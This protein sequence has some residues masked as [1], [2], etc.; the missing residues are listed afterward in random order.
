MWRLVMDDQ[1]VRMEKPLGI[2]EASRFTGLKPSYLYKLIHLKRIPYY[3]P[4]GGRVYFKQSELEAFIF[5]GRQAS[6]YERGL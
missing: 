1:I 6:D 2:D 3:K 5:R 4:T